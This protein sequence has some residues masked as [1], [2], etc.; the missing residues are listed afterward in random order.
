M[1]TTK[2]TAPKKAQK[3]AQP[4]IITGTPD[5]EA[6]AGTDTTRTEE[7]VKEPETVGA[8]SAVPVTESCGKPAWEMELEA[9]Y[10]HI[11]RNSNQTAILAAILTELV[12]IRVQRG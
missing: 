8:V 6:V 11:I 12:R 9:K 4:D 3:S 2:K 5:I 10:G 1:A 7:T